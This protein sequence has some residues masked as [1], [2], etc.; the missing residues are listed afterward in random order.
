MVAILI[1]I[2]K[3]KSFI[4][5]LHTYI[6]VFFSRIFVA[7][8]TMVMYDGEQDMRIYCLEG[9]GGFARSFC[10]NSFGPMGFGFWVDQYSRTV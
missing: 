3:N 4:D 2:F 1:F 8:K 6:Y 9:N 5:I 7:N 10:R